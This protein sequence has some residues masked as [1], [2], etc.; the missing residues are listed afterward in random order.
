LVAK[1]EGKSEEVK[2]AQEEK[3]VQLDDP[4]PAGSTLRFGTSRFRHGI[5]VSTMAVS[6]DGK[7]AVAV[8]GNHMLGAT[9]VFDLASGRAL[10]SLDQGGFIEAAAISPDGRTIVTK[11][12]FSLRVRDAL[13][14]RNFE[15]SNCNAPIR[16]A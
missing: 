5:P 16:T 2:P 1:G 11:Q 6:A 7:I 3:V 12:D 10:Y 13:P 14:E 4:L 9:R 15:R 8:N